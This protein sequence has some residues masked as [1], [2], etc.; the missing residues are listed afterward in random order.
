MGIRAPSNRNA[1]WHGSFLESRFELRT[2]VH[3]LSFPC[4]SITMC[5]LAHN[6]LLFKCHSWASLWI[7]IAAVQE[8]PVMAQTILW[9]HTNLGWPLCWHWQ[10]TIQQAQVCRNKEFTL[11]LVPVRLHFGNIVSNTS[12][13]LPNVLPCLCHSSISNFS[14]RNTSEH[15]DSTFLLCCLTLRS[16]KGTSHA[17]PLGYPGHCYGNWLQQFRVMTYGKWRWEILT[18]MYITENNRWCYWECRHG[19]FLFRHVS[20]RLVACGIPCHDYRRFSPCLVN[21]AKLYSAI[22][23]KASSGG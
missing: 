23:P 12:S 2:H 4:L 22:L 13:Q 8:P 16:P 11:L 9:S 18:W 1:K 21:S 10:L 3:P 20:G 15:Q 19:R 7:K 6:R 14:C 17:L 5:P